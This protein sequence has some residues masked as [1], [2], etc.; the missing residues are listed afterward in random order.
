MRR[1]FTAMTVWVALAA[2]VPVAFAQ[3]GDLKVEIQKPASGLRLQSW[4]TSWRG[5]LRS[6]AA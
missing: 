6:S 2:T 3:T 4:E 5:V 1:L